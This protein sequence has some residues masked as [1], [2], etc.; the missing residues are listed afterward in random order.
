MYTKQF[1]NDAT[2]HEK[3]SSWL[4]QRAFLGTVFHPRV[5]RPTLE[6]L[7]M[8]S[9]QT[10]VY[11]PRG[12]G[13]PLSKPMPEPVPP[14]PLGLVCRWKRLALEEDT[15]IPMAGTSHRPGSRWGDSAGFHQKASLSQNLPAGE[16]PQI[17]NNRN[18]DETK[19]SAFEDNTEKGGAGQEQAVGKWAPEFKASSPGKA[20]PG[21]GHLSQG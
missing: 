4:L 6:G 2:W 13:A 1:F 14:S 11:C 9:R 12:P 19:R 21:R 5:Q 3:F 7:L 20:S 17:N 8:L 15:A 16:G 10:A 18:I